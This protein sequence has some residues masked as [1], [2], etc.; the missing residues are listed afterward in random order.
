MER[1]TA[2][3]G[4]SR[5]APGG[6]EVLESTPEREPV[7]VDAPRPEL[8]PQDTSFRSILKIALFKNY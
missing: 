1:G 4:G 5:V 3:L 2:D 8:S 7:G 6:R